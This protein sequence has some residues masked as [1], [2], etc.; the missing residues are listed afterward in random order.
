M[1]AADVT[2]GRELEKKINELFADA[3]VSY[4]HLHTAKQGCYLCRVDRSV[5]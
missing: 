4:L 1:V 5:S 2:E 3:G